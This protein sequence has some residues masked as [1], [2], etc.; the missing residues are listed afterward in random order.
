MTSPLTDT[1]G[2]PVTII[3]H[4]VTVVPVCPL[5]TAHLERHGEQFVADGGRYRRP[6]RADIDLVRRTMASEA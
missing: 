1:T 4:D 2:A 6:T 3:R 5:F